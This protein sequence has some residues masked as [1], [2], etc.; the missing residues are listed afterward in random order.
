[1]ESTPA[2]AGL[3][4][5]W[6]LKQLLSIGLLHAAVLATVYFP[7]PVGDAG[8]TSYA[9]V[10]RD[11][12]FVSYVANWA[13]SSAACNL[14]ARMRGSEKL[15]GAIAVPIPLAVAGL[16]WR[17]IG[18][19]LAGPSSLGW[20]ATTPVAVAVATSSAP[21]RGTQPTRGLTSDP[22]VRPTNGVT[23]EPTVGTVVEPTV[24]PTAEAPRAGSTQGAN[25]VKTGENE[26]SFRRGSYTRFRRMAYSRFG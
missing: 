13:G 11:A 17:I 18:G 5:G 21:A 8:F 16:G 22:R 6:L 3:S 2:R 20:P 9:I 14:F 1:V 15:V 19:W 4:I 23:V 24:R 26:Q 7:L 25:C 12:V 10:L